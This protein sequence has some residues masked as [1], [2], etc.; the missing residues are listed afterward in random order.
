M[1]DHLEA[2]LEPSTLPAL[3]ALIAEQEA[4]LAALRFDYEN[5]SWGMGPSYRSRIAQEEARL[6]ELKRMK[7]G[8]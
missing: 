2:I 6:R 5:S 7:A 8:A 4:T 1:L 3:D